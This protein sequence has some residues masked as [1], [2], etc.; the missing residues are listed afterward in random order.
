MFY[1]EGETGIFVGSNRLTCILVPLN[2]HEMDE[3]HTTNGIADIEL[4]MMK[5][6]IGFLPEVRVL[7][8][9]PI[10][11]RQILHWCN[12]KELILLL[13]KNNES[14][15]LHQQLT[16]ASNKF[17]ELNSA[18]TTAP[19]DKVSTSNAYHTTENKETQSTT[20]LNQMTS[21]PTRVKVTTTAEA[22][23]SATSQHARRATTPSTYGPTVIYDKSS[24]GSMSAVI[25]DH[26]VCYVYH[27]TDTDIQLVN[28][29]SYIRNA[30]ERALLSKDKSHVI[31]NDMYIKGASS[32]V[33]EECRGSVFEFL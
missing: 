24:N 28:M 12:S 23:A 3:V 14:T 22:P 31:K 5:E 7:R 20:L 32:I 11:S 2:K 4:K 18:R 8:S 30:F 17:P 26:D 19:S 27:L 21:S 29:E 6:W 9:D 10:A 15:T 16:T 33:N 13:R 25:V 1:F